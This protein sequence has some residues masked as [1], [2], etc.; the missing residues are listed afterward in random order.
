MNFVHIIRNLN[1]AVVQ[2]FGSS[3]KG[4]IQSWHHTYSLQI[5]YWIEFPYDKFVEGNGYG[6]I[7]LVSLL[8]KSNINSITRL[9]V[10]YFNH[11]LIRVSPVKNIFI[12][13]VCF[14]SCKKRVLLLML[15]C[16]AHLENNSI[17]MRRICQLDDVKCYQ[18][19]PQCIQCV[20]IWN[21]QNLFDVC[22]CLCVDSMPW[23][24]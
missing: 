18:N 19:Y 16:I 20:T 2:I 5:S 11:H 6:R 9:N 3:S 21:A 23:T 13:V 1:W 15:L 4:E 17:G 8:L 22:V 14:G 24:V 10:C 7:I 12:A